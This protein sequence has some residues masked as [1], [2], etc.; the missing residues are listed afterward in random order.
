MC[1]HPWLTDY[2]CAFSAFSTH[3]QRKHFSR[4]LCQGTTNGLW[5]DTKEVQEVPGDLGGRS[6][7]EYGNNHE[8]SNLFVTFI[9]AE[10]LA[11]LFG[12]WWSGSLV[13]H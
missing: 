11:M 8:I 4:L 10:L 2:K 7:L 1:S 12:T 13:I 3:C 5:K 6:F 9:F